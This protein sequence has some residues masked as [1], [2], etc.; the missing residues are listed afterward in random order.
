MKHAAERHAAASGVPTTVVR[1]TAF[2]ELWVDLLRR[3]AA[4]S[5]RPL[6]F[7]RG[8]N[9]VNL[10]SVVDV[11]ALVDRAVTDA[12]TRG[13][14]LEIGGPDN[15]SFNDLALAVQT[16]D[17]RTG[18]PRHVPPAMLRLMAETIG[19]IQ[20]QLGR[21]ARAALALD[22]GDHTFDATEIHRRYPGLPTTTL[23]G[24]LGV[25]V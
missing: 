9:P 15:I 23:A 19:R 17:G 8:D 24:V 18:P 10:V 3:T 21:Q 25:P 5:G 1:A 11:A 13:Q 16:A 12:L 4:R 6:V 20:P 22:S 2:M 14:T 7:G